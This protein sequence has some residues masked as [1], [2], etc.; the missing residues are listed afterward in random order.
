MW[1]QLRGLITSEPVRPFLPKTRFGGL[2]VESS[3]AFFK[4]H[5][6]TRLPQPAVC[7]TSLSGRLCRP[8]P[9]VSTFFSLPLSL[10]CFS[11]LLREYVSPP[12]LLDVF[13][14]KRCEDSCLGGLP[15]LTFP[16]PLR[17]GGHSGASGIEDCQTPASGSL[18]PWSS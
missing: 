1:D 16:S 7:C 14:Q 15:R 13:L 17:G 10:F 3:T 5:N 18:S 12:C 6:K 11:L 2:L 4:F 8:F 9:L